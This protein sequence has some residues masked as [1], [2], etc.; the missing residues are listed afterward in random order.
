MSMKIFTLTKEQILPISVETAWE[1]FSNPNNLNKITPKDMSFEIRTE[2]EGEMY[3]G[4]LIDYTVKPILNIPMAWTTEITHVKK[5]EYF[6]DEQRFGPYKLWHHEHH[7]EKTKHGVLITDKLLYGLSFGLIGNALNS[8]FISRRIQEIFDF[9][10]D[11]LN[12]LFPKM[13]K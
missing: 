2:L 9:R 3:A 1:F 13:V 12:E 4:M 10:Y 8:L 5:G 6:I 7:F 11:K